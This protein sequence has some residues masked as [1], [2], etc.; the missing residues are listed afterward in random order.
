[1]CVVNDMFYGAV[2]IEVTVPHGW[3]NCYT[4]LHIELGRIKF[5]WQNAPLWGIIVLDFY[6]DYWID[7][8]DLEVNKYA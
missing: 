2:Y 3:L 6:K 5:G 8:A 1:M 7:G 4:L